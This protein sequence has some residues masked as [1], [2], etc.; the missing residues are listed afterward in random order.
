MSKRSRTA[1]D[2]LT[3]K[4]RREAHCAPLSDVTPK[5]RNYSNVKVTPYFS[6]P[7]DDV[8]LTFDDGPSRGLTIPFL[9]ML[10][11]FRCVATFF[12]IG[13]A[14]L[15]RKHLTRRIVLE[16]HEVANHTMTHRDLTDLSASEVRSE[17]ADANDVIASITGQV[18]RYFRPPYGKYNDRILQT[19]AELGLATVL[20]SVHADDWSWPGAAHIVDTTIREAQGGS[21]ILFHDGCGHLPINAAVPRK[22]REQNLEAMPQVLDGLQKRGFRMRANEFAST[23]NK[24]R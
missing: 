7:S 20:W 16:G 9:D 2:S 1:D 15:R 5:R 19:A 18:P 8:W 14:V 12:V 4:R 24:A 10:R 17:I 3:Q 21:I 13:M 22:T 6:I 11:Q 23:R